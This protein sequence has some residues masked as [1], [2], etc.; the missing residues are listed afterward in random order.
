MEG[1]LNSAISESGEL[2][3]LRS[4]YMSLEREREKY[5]QRG[6]K[7]K[8]PAWVTEWSF[9]CAIR[10]GLMVWIHTVVTT[11]NLS[12]SSCA[13]FQ[14]QPAA[15]QSTAGRA[16]LAGMWTQDGTARPRNKD[17]LR[18]YGEK[19]NSTQ[20]IV[21]M[22]VLSKPCMKKSGKKKK[23]DCSIYAFYIF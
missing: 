9:R 19:F 6:E 4:L 22:E 5:I 23:I 21:H 16:L 18:H 1:S 12:V 2:L 14:L 3:P 10:N 7:E 17:D 20:R 8:H 11:G 13:V 15:D